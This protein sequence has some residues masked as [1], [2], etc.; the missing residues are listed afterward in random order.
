[1]EFLFVITKNNPEFFYGQVVRQTVIN[2]YCGI[3]VCS[4]KEQTM[5]TCNNNSEFREL[6]WMKKP[7]LK[8]FIPYGSIYGTFLKWQ[9]L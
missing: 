3:L 4:M 8:G 6:C 7:I 1:M 9:K 5:D 2:P